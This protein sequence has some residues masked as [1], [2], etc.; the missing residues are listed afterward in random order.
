MTAPRC[1]VAGA[2]FETCAR[3]LDRTYRLMPT[4][5][6]KQLFLYVLGIAAQRFNVTL[7]GLVVMMNHYHLKGHDNDGRLPRFKQYANSLIARALNRLQG[8]QDSLWS[9]RPYGH[10][11]PGD[12]DDLMRRM[13]YIMAN[14]AAADLVQRAEEFPGLIILPSDI[15]RSIEVERPSFFFRKSMPKKVTLRFEM[16]P[17]F[18]EMGLEAY[19]GELWD[20]LRAAEEMHR[21]RRKRDKKGVLGKRR[22]RRT[23]LHG[24]P[25]QKEKAFGMRPAVSA[26]SQET[27][28]QALRELRT[29]RDAYRVAYAAWCR[30][31]R[32]TAFPP[33][34]YRM[35]TMA[36]CPMST[37]GEAAW[38]TNARPSRPPLVAP[39]RGGRASPSPA[40]RGVPS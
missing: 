7:Y 35:C 36:G 27:R 22:C 10:L 11:R 26:A 2:N 14:P 28:R 30:G 16:P 17:E 37:A 18:E 39:A 33:G 21:N 6:V 25:H 9:G 20:H 24:R 31:D 3:T 32:E 29:F 19:A 12:A 23:A 15:G 40:S 1:I 13:S 5:E 4:P 38:L 8:T 34:T